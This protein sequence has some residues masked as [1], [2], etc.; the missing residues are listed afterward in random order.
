MTQNRSSQFRHGTNDVVTMDPI[1]KFLGSRVIARGTCGT[2]YLNCRLVLAY[3]HAPRI[4]LMDLSP[5]LSAPWWA[6]RYGVLLRRIEF[7]VQ[8]CGEHTC[9]S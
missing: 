2:R 6:L 8:F 5:C 7:S 3:A 1:I 4:Y 9:I